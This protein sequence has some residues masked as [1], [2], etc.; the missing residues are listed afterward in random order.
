MWIKFWIKSSR[1]TDNTTHRWIPKQKGWTRA[2]YKEEIKCYLEDWIRNWNHLEYFRYGYIKRKP[3]PK[4][5]RE[6]I[7]AAM[8]RVKDANRHLAFLKKQFP[9]KK[10]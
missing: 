2:Q 9:R 10:R 7:E 3:T 8:D 5:Q 6:M 4:Q 1:G